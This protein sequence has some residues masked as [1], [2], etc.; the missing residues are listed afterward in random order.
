MSPSRWPTATFRDGRYPRL[1]IVAGRQEQEAFSL[2]RAVHQQGNHPGAVADLPE[3]RQHAH[4]H[5]HPA[6]RCVGRGPARSP[7]S[8]RAGRCATNTRYRSAR[9]GRAVQAVAGRRTVES[10]DPS[11]RNIRSPASRRRSSGHARRLLDPHRGFFTS[12]SV[13]YASRCS[14]RNGFLRGPA[15]RFYLPVTGARRWR[16]PPLGPHPALPRMLRGPG[17]EIARCG[18]SAVLSASRPVAKARTRLRTR[19]PGDLC[20]DDE[21]PHDPFRRDLQADAVATY[22]PV[23]GVSA[24]Y[25]HWA[26]TPWRS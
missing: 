17:E 6:A 15:R 2:S 12:A 9:T 8:E 22:D 24:R 13:E 11:L 16:C 1:E 5:A 10:L 23:T 4:R 26:E 20:L 3:R 14:G 7:W 19:P 18:R 25:C 21:S